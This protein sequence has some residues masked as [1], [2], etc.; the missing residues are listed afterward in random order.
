MPTTDERIAA[1]EAKIDDLQAQI[2]KLGQRGSM[3]QTFTCPA[4]GNGNI[5]AVNQ[6]KSPSGMGGTPLALKSYRR[7]FEGPEGD[8]LYVYVCTACRLVEWH[9]HSLVHLAPDGE[10]VVE[11]TRTNEQAAPK[12][13]PYR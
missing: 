3:H 13:S 6:V 9:V 1:M 4:C 8:P 10:T 12:G 7:W 5:L 11:L 2:A